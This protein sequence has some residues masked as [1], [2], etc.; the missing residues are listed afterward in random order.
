MLTG[1]NSFKISS[2][3]FLFSSPRSNGLKSDW[4]QR[5]L[6]K[7]WH[8]SSAHRALHSRFS[9]GRV[10]GYEL[11]KL[12]QFGRGDLR[13]LVDKISWNCRHVDYNAGWDLFKWA[14][15]VVTKQFENLDALSSFCKGAGV[16]ERFLR[17]SNKD[18]NRKEHRLRT[19]C[20]VL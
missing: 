12:L 10:C 15:K 11:R 8:S 17:S 6:R 16:S 14:T 19:I 5:G 3:F 18:D 1:S 13:E 7:N 20:R 9:G 4:S 2:F